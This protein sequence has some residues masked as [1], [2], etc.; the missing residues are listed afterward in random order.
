VLSKL[1]AIAVVGVVLIALAATRA[2]AQEGGPRV[3]DAAPDFTLAGATQ[4]GVMATPLHLA[5]FRGQTVV[6]A[7]F[8]K[9]RTKG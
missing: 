3:G 6:L 2:M 8:P 1:G 9:A 7:F 4:A 5:D